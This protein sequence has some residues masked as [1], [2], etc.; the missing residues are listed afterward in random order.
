MKQLIFFVIVAGC[1]CASALGQNVA[2]KDIRSFYIEGY[3]KALGDNRRVADCL[4]PLLKQRGAFTFTSIKETAEAIL[5]IDATVPGGRDRFLWKSPSV[6]MT[7][8]T[9]DGRILWKGEN[10]YRKWGDATDVACGLANGIAD[11]LVKAM[12]GK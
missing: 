6:R 2:F 11:K 3:D 10:T 9:L 7:V 5:T 8:V 12:Q 1:L 4:M